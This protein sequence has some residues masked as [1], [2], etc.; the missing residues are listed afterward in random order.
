[1]ALEI[2]S[3]GEIRKTAGQIIHRHL[4]DQ[5]VTLSDLAARLKTTPQNLGNKLKRGNLK[6][7][8][9]A[10]IST[11]LRHNFFTDLAEQLQFNTSTP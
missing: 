7:S 8:E 10:K 6:V 1:M 11:A 3:D 5:R 9:V 4:Y 2:N